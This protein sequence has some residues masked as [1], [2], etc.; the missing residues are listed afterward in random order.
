MAVNK[1]AKLL[2]A[3]V[4]VVALAGFGVYAAR[5][6]LYPHELER[7]PPKLDG[8][9]QAIVDEV[10]LEANVTTDADL[11]SEDQAE[12]VTVTFVFVPPALDKNDT[13]HKV[14]EL[15]K[16]YLPKARIVEVRFGDNLRV[17]PLSVEERAPSQQLD[18]G[19][20]KQR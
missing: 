9:K 19:M 11:G 14:R 3:I 10:H 12:K 7:N 4:G 8:I 16:A 2:L 20:P 13:E 6:V 17:R 18:T 5:T 1:V 15:V